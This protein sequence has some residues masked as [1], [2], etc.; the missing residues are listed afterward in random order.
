MDYRYIVAIVTGGIFFIAAL[1]YVCSAL[2][3]RHRDKLKKIEEYR[4]YSDPNLVRMDYD[5]AYYDAETEQRLKALSEGDTQMSMDDVL[6]SAAAAQVAAFT[7][8]EAADDGEITGNY[9]P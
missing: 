8:I 6:A 4:V 5:M 9:K 3:R 7:R 2:R 1:V